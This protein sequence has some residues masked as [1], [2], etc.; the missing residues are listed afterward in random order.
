MMHTI[1]FPPV[2]ARTLAKDGWTKQDIKEFIGEYAR[3]PISS[4]TSSSGPGPVKLYKGKI[5]PRPWETV[6]IIN[7]IRTIRIMVAGGP[8]AFIAQAVGG[9]P[10]PGKAEIRKIELP[11]NWSRLVAKYKNIVPDYLRY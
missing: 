8:G 5:D 10:T 3:M 7:D 2:H 1:I 4:R 11:E 9:G 6:P